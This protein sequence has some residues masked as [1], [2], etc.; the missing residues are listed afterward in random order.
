MRLRAGTILILAGS[1]ALVWCLT[2][3][4]GAALYDYFSMGHLERTPDTSTRTPQAH[5][6]KP[7]D[8]LGRIEIPRLHLS[9]VV[10]E[11]DDDGALRYGAG[12]VPSTAF[13]G[14]TGNVG[15]AAHRDTF[16]RPL[17]HIA[18]QD[19]I[20]LTTSEGVYNYVVESTELVS[21][22]DIRVLD[23]TRDPEL[24]LI[25]CYPFYFI[26]PAPKRFIV[27]ARR[28]S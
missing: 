19:R 12:H 16:F 2:V 10:L 26:G 21:P 18:A 20:T 28:T 5:K 27:H 6:S 22:K 14:E 24:T 9:T 4:A 13:P 15:I 23:P 3:L 11:G 8:V 17:R 7:Y 25:T 1:A